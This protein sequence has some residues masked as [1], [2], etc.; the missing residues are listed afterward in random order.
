MNISG[1]CFWCVYYGGIER[2]LVEVIYWI[3]IFVEKLK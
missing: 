2:Y 1:L 3:V